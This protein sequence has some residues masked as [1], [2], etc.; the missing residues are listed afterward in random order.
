M[1]PLN[2]MEWNLKT[3]HFFFLGGGGG[4]SSQENIMQWL[5]RVDMT[6]AALKIQCAYRRW[7]IK[8]KYKRLGAMFKKLQVEVRRW[9]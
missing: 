3:R 5:S 2:R 8:L 7:I 4:G 9:C 6:K 1:L